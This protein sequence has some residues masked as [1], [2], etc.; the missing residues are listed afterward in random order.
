MRGSEDGS[1]GDEMVTFWSDRRVM[2]MVTVWRGAR[3][4]EGGRIDPY[5]TLSLS[6]RFIFPAS[7]LNCQPCVFK[8]DNVE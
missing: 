3:E 8:R 4:I 7:R 1:R 5:L 2:G 6:N